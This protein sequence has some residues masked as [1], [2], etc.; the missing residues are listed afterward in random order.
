MGGR[1]CLR[2]PQR[3]RSRRWSSRDRSSVG[4]SPRSGGRYRTG[5]CCRTFRRHDHGSS[6]AADMPHVRDGARVAWTRLLVPVVSYASWLTDVE[7]LAPTTVA[8]YVGAVG[9]M[10]EYAHEEGIIPA[11]PAAHVPR[12]PR[13]RHATAPWLTADQLRKLL[14]V[15]P[16]AGDDASAAVH[17]LAL[18][19]IRVGEILRL[20]VTD[21]PRG[22]WHAMRASE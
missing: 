9:L 4:V 7:H 20:H 12:G 19:G 14:A 6:W 18:N 1:L 8:G 22:R 2:R 17:L 10:L 13:S 3:A 16:A 15:I 21:P 5:G 11:N